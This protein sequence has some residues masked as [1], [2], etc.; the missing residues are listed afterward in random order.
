MDWTLRK[1]AAFSGVPGPVVVCVMDGVGI[2]A[3]D[4]GDAVWRAR[5]PTLDRLANGALASALT[6]HGTA[7]GLPRDDDMGNSEVG[8]NAIGAGRIFAQ[9]A[10]LV[11]LAIE[12]GSI[13]DSPVWHQLLDHG[14]R[15]TLH[16]LGL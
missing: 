11:N 5:K 8:H 14:R 2:G 16:L 3:H 12:S 13:W 9:G 7:V 4:A 1:S 6:A 10:K 15:H